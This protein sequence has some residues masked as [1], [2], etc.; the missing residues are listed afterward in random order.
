MNQQAPQS[1]IST[2]N[3]SASISAC[4]QDDKI[5]RYAANKHRGGSSGKKGSRYEDIFIGYKVAEIVA[6]RVGRPVNSWPSVAGQTEEFVDDALVRRHDCVQYFQLKNV[7]SISWTGG[8]HPLETDFSLQYR[9]ACFQGNQNPTTTLVVPDRALQ[10]K[11]QATIPSAISGYSNVQ[12][13]PYS[14]TLNRLVL[15][16]PSLHTAL[17][18]LARSRA[19]HIDELVGVLWVL[20][21]AG[22]DFGCEVSVE[23]I[24]HAAARHV[25]NQLRTSGI[26]TPVVLR[27]A[28]VEILDR[29]AGLKYDASQGFFSWDAF[30][31]SEIFDFDC[32]T[33]QFEDFQKLIEQENPMT[34]E[35]FE[36][37][38]P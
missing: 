7:Q 10:A 4:F 29:I 20:T 19:P 18:T 17:G 14:E 36:E 26:T 3:T 23:E 34:F 33:S 8:D 16:N 24:L 35:R 37:L 12:F 28:F 30:G 5:V 32:A 31:T 13:F 11:L 15:E 25:P 2:T 27:T 6:S 21:M 22:N 1:V 38:L 9:L